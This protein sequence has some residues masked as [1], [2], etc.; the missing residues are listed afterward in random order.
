M[1]V[2]NK[3][4]EF[5]DQAQ[6]NSTQLNQVETIRVIDAIKHISEDKVLIEKAIYLVFL[7]NKKQPN[8]AKLSKRENEIIRYIGLGFTSSEIGEFTSI[9]TAT[10]STHRK[11]IIK[12]LKLSGPGQLQ[13]I[14][15]QWV[16]YQPQNKIRFEVTN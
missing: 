8:I 7:M 14:A 12:K 1:K 10:V 16:F 11:N 9:S 2:L 4:L 3:I 13:K 15:L 6:E 5:I